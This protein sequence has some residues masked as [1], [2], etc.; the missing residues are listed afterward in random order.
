MPN[1][2][3][4]P[5][6]EVMP[7]RHFAGLTRR[8]DM[9]TRSAIPAQWADYNTAGVVLPHAIPDAWYGLCYNFGPDMSF[10][11]LSGQEVSAVADLPPGFAAVTIAGT[12]ARFATKGH[13]STMQ[14]AL[15]E[16]YGDWLKRPDYQPRPGPSVEYYPLEFDGMTGDG[17]YEIWV[18]VA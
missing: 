7:P 13:I 17:G 8:Y 18:P 14:A 16:I 6:I 1:L 3:A 5:K 10:D 9:Q 11:Y 15:G 2:F 12:Y 4:A